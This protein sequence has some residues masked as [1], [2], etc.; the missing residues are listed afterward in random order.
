MAPGGSNVLFLLGAPRSG[1]T[2]LAKIF[3]S[4]PDVLYRH[5]PDTVLR[6]QHLP[7]LCPRGEVDSYRREARQYLLRLLNVRTQKSA[8]SLPTFPKSYNGPV[9]RAVRTAYI[10][11]PR[12]LERLTGAKWPRQIAIPDLVQ[13]SERQPIVVMKS[14]SARG[15]ARLFAE[16]LPASRII[17]ILRHP[18]GQVAS[19]VT[20]ISKGKLEGDTRLREILST[21]E[22][23]QYGLTSD[24]F[25]ALP[26]L[27]KCAWHWAILNQKAMNDLAGLDRVLTVRYEDLCRQPEEVART[28][29]GFARLPWSLQT[30][31]FLQKSTTGSDTDDYFKTTRDSLAAADK[32]R[33]ELSVDEQERVLDVARKVPVGILAVGGN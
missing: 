2:W 19:L 10:Y 24:I 14:V 33:H 15:R 16:A 9:S 27:E 29:F 30:Q 23:G 31:S 4:H 8:G 12:V 3:D 21:E 17:F 22:A 18:C 26:L 13:S 32:W 25:D 28:M 6:N 20:G 11:A 7:V 1:T 5:E